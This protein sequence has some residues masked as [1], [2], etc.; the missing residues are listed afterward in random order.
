MR[1]IKFRGRLEESD[2][3]IC[4]ERSIN[5]QLTITA[6]RN[7]EAL[8]SWLTT[9]IGGNYFFM[10]GKKDFKN[11]PTGIHKFIYRAPVTLFPEYRRT[12]ELFI[13][14]LIEHFLETE[15]DRF[16]FPLA[17]CYNLIPLVNA[18]TTERCEIMK[19]GH[20][21]D[22][23]TCCLLLNEAFSDFRK[24]LTASAVNNVMWCFC[25]NNNAIYS[26]NDGIRKIFIS[27]C[28][29][30]TTEYAYRHA[31]K[32]EKNRF[33]C[34]FDD[35]HSYNHSWHKKYYVVSEEWCTN[36]CCGNTAGWNFFAFN[37]F[38]DAKI[39]IM[40]LLNKLN[41]SE[42]NALLQAGEY[43]ATEIT[44]SFY[45]ER[46]K[47]GSYKLAEETAQ[48]AR[49]NVAQKISSK[50]ILN[51]N[52]DIKCYAPCRL[53]EKHVY[54]FDMGNGTVKIGITQDIATRRA[55]IMGHS[56]LFIKHFAYTK[57]LPDSV[58]SSIEKNLHSIFADYHTLGEFFRIDYDVAKEYLQRYAPD[59]L[60]EVL[61]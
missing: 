29:L 41:N 22:L 6:R 14:L 24:F 37:S 1:T 27:E 58:A 16:N 56:G 25:D 36:A 50:K 28:N 57:P 59:Q 35:E 5:L 60:T 20:E 49:N 7:I 32:S 2:K 23:E 45:K 18:A 51:A 10:A 15:K 11:Q 34:F 61:L 42:Q 46:R 52:A 3:I 30:P 48:I 17:V 4:F 13:N 40:R 31:K 39:F 33:S 12:M 55:T 53:G 43:L 26:A 19:V 47:I 38:K 54:A 44:K 8:S 21:G 9:E